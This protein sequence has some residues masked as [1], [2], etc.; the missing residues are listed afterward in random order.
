MIYIYNY[1]PQSSFL[2]VAWESLLRFLEINSAAW[3]SRSKLLFVASWSWCYSFG[4]SWTW[5]FWWVCWADVHACASVSRS[6][7]WVPHGLV[8]LRAP[9]CQKLLLYMRSLWLVC[10]DQV[11][12]QLHSPVSVASP[13]LS[14]HGL[15]F[16]LCISKETWL[17][18]GK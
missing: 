17:F 9:L 6:R 4:T 10:S 16:L 5:R 14:D 1:S 15:R 8:R 7:R 2:L 11:S 18:L 3:L 12:L 13:C